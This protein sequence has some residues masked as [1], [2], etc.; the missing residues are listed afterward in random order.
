MARAIKTTTATAPTTNSPEGAKGE[1]G[2]EGGR[3]PP[4]L[5]RVAPLHMSTALSCP[6][7]LEGGFQVTTWVSWGARARSNGGRDNGPIIG[8]AIYSARGSEGNEI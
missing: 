6:F 2:K 5:D 1:G 3:G 4:S 7:E 8:K